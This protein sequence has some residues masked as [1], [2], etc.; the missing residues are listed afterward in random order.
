M[1]ITY[2]LWC[3]VFWII[4]GILKNAVPEVVLLE[5]LCHEVY[6]LLHVR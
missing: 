6:C 5:C 1:R 2:V 4:F 3:F